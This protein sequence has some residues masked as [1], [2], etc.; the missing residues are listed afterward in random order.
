MEGISTPL[1]VV[2]F[3]NLIDVGFFSNFQIFKDF[4]DLCLEIL[5]ES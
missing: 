3:C 4:F 1:S 5:K 2:K